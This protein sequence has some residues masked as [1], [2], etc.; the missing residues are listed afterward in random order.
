MPG[1]TSLKGAA[2][3][4][5]R[6]IVCQSLAAIEESRRVGPVLIQDRQL[7]CLSFVPAQV[8]LAPL[9]RSREN[10]A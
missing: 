7:A 8:A 4:D 9:Y 1:V 6:D 10:A 2:A 5:I 3:S